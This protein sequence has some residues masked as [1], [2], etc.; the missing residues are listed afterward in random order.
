VSPVSRRRARLVDNRSPGVARVQLWR[1]PGS[2]RSKAIAQVNAVLSAAQSG[3][4]V[5]RAAVV[6]VTSPELWP[7]VRTTIANRTLVYDCMD[8]ALAFDQDEGVRELKAAWERELLARSD[9]VACSSNELAE[10]ASA[11][12]A[13][14]AR[15]VVVPNGW[16]PQ[17]FPIR[18]SS[19]LPREGRLE[20]A[21][22]GTIASWIDFDALLAVTRACPHVSVRMIGPRDQG[23]PSRLPGLVLEPPV[24]HHA[25]AQAVEGAHAL[26]VPF[27]VNALT[28][29]VDPVKLYE[30]I[31][32]GKPIL[33][34]H[35]PA[36]DRFAGMLTFYRD[37]AQLVDLI[38]ARNVPAPPDR[39]ARAAF[40]A[41]QSWSARA[42][43]LRAAIQRS[44]SG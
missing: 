21:Y 15:T 36:L 44:A 18:T 13:A 23:V 29:A 3:P 8:D 37:A 32:L 22:F 33:A 12:G 35:W 11:R 4:S 19:A 20:L 42:A 2:Y 9:V 14:A 41:P 43:A 6:L 25:L 17:A 34:S 28:R 31:A 7:W 30:Y 39:D 27:R 26:L 40:L 1:L 5:R 16:D 10:R 38:S 24:E